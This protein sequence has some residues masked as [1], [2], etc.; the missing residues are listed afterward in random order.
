LPALAGM[1]IHFKG[2]YAAYLGFQ[3]IKIVCGSEGAY[4]LQNKQNMGE[5][6]TF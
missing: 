1:G 5:I 3:I 2:K 4:L 6:V